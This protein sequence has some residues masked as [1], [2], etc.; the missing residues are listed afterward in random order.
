[1]MLNMKYNFKEMHTF[2]HRYKIFFF[3]NKSQ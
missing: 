3:L 1:M 2:I